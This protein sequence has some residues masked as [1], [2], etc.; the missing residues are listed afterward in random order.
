M[1]QLCY[2]SSKI[3]SGYKQL[4]PRWFNDC[5]RKRIE[6]LWYIFLIQMLCKYSHLP[7]ISKVMA[8]K[9]AA[10]AFDELWYL[11]SE[12]TGK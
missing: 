4:F 1:E 3:E 7:V 6:N 10:L 9:G 2:V 12:I 11:L 8:S 5:I